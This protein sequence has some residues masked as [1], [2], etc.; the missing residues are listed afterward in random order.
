MPFD[1]NDPKIREILGD[2]EIDLSQV[3]ELN[4]DSRNYLKI[5]EGQ[6]YSFLEINSTV[7][8]FDKEEFDKIINTEIT[9]LT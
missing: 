4:R 9:Q 2:Q 7:E 5:M 8:P 1:I 3:E 6:Q